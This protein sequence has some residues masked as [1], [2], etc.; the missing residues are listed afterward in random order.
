MTA[1]ILSDRAL[2]FVRE[3]LLSVSPSAS[4][5]PVKNP[6]FSSP[7]FKPL[8]FSTTPSTGTPTFLQKLSSFRTSAMAISWGVVTINAPLIPACFR[9]CTIER[10]SSLVPGGASTTRKSNS[11]HSVSF[12]NCL[13]SPFFRGPRQITASSGLG[14]RKP[15]LITARFSA[16]YTGCH[17]EALLCTSCPSAANMMGALGPQMSMS[18]RPTSF[19]GSEAKPYASCD[20]NVLFPTPPFPDKTR[21]LCFT[22]FSRSATATTSGSTPLGAVAQAFWL[23]HPAHP[24]R[25]PASSASVPGHDSFASAGTL[26]GVSVFVM[27][28]GAPVFVWDGVDT[29]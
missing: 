21:I 12:R 16:T 13:I 25:V 19:S 20:A 8:M 3:S 26:S 5:L 4:A 10:C 29:N 1:L 23:G 17:P 28:S 9:Y 2:E 6:T 27:V 15:M 11:P 24:G 14:S 7:T 18:N 22:S